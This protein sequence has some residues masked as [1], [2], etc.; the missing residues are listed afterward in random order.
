MKDSIFENNPQMNDWWRIHKT[1][2]QYL[3]IP[4]FL[5]G[6]GYFVDDISPLVEHNILP[7]MHI[8]LVIKLNREI[9]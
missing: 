9:Q 7:I 2:S 8:K 4:S 1:G 5:S 3:W 6:D